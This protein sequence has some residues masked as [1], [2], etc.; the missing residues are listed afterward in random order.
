M[1][2]IA[3][4][5]DK[6]GTRQMTQQSE[7]IE[8][9]LVAP[10]LT[11]PEDAINSLVGTAALDVLA[12]KYADMPCSNAEE[13]EAI[14]KGLADCRTRRGAISEKAAE[15]KKPAQ[16]WIKTVNAESDRLISG[17]KA[18]EGPIKDKRTSYETEQKEER[19]KAR[20]LEEEKTNKIKLAIQS[21]QNTGAQIAA[22]PLEAAKQA[23]ADL[24]AI[25]VSEEH[26]GDLMAVA[27][28]V[29][30][31]AV[32]S[33]Q[34][35]I[36]ELERRAEEAAALAA[37]KAAFEAE[38]AAAEEAK[39][40]ADEAAAAKA[41]EEAKA[42][43]IANEQA[44]ATLKAQQEQAAALQAQIDKQNEE[45]ERQRLELAQKAAEAANR[46]RL[47]LIALDEPDAYKE[48][49]ERER[50]AA[51]AQAEAEAEEARQEAIA[52]AKRK[53]TAKALTLE[54]IAKLEASAPDMK[55]LIKWAKSAKAVISEQPDSATDKG[56]E[57][58]DQFAAMIA[59]AANWLLSEALE[60][61]MALNKL[62]DS[63]E[64]LNEV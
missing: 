27:E 42:L 3:L 40:A 35:A 5:S 4:H 38:K 36:A 12:T 7:A 61:E 37:E 58:G 51:Q 56:V 55:Q 14:R 6:T 24:E 48:H 45:M 28:T 49:E 46:D 50:V 47:A 19:A 30:A 22:M 16:E 21:M 1:Y 29:K 41:A 31:G 63:L 43:Q 62:K 9:E 57:L 60:H 11:N 39:R 34:T 20:K 10:S 13:S 26:Y 54:E 23:L 2:S 32:M 59:K 52:A 64:A 17:L 53:E 44:A 18:I 8:G 33:G 25:E 15:Y